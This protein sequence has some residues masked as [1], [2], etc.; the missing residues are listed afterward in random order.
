M[1][2]KSQIISMPFQAMHGMVW[3]AFPCLAMVW[4]AL[5]CHGIVWYGM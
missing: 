1:Q 4:Y 3:Y 5:P 2:G